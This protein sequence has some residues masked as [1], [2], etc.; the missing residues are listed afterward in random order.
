MK[1]LLLIMLLF[2]LCL[3]GCGTNNPIIDDDSNE[4]KNLIDFIELIKNDNLTDLCVI[5]NNDSYQIIV[6]KMEN[7]SRITKEYVFSFDETRDIILN[8]LGFFS[9]YVVHMEEDCANSLKLKLL[10]DYPE[11]LKNV[12]YNDMPAYYQ[13][14]N[15]IFYEFVSQN[16]QK[17]NVFVND[18]IYYESY[19]S[20]RKYVKA[21]VSSTL[22]Y[23]K[24]QDKNDVDTLPSIKSYLSKGD[25]INFEEGLVYASSESYITTYTSNGKELK[26]LNLHNYPFVFKDEIIDFSK[27]S[28]YSISEFKFF[29]SRGNFIFVW[30]DRNEKRMIYKEFNENTTLEELKK[31]LNETNLITRWVIYVDNSN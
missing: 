13:N 31:V 23:I 14:R 6:T 29:G 2:G 9:K 26:L 22:G 27:M 18:F 21:N 4:N 30:G 25:E 15:V 19:E 7:Y 17:I 5:S 11:A 16:D 10:Y 28:D 8:Q 24:S 20:G 1:K 12:D 3:F